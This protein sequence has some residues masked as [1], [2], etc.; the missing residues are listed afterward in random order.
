[1][2]NDHKPLTDA[3]AAR[4]RVLSDT[5][6]R[7]RER[8]EEDPAQIWVLRESVEL[9]RCLRRLVPGCTV[10]Q[11]HEAFGA[12]GDFGYENPVGAALAKV[13]RG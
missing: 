9:I 2:P 7:L 1:M 3:L 8:D 6:D 12:P 13:Y 4:E 5:I 10:D 11:I